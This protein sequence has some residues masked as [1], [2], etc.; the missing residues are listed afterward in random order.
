M[1]LVRAPGDFHQGEHGGAFDIDR[2][3]GQGEGL[4][5][6]RQMRWSAIAFRCPSKRVWRSALASLLCVALRTGASHSKFSL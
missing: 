5:V 1:D 3:G 2:I 4:T 6:D